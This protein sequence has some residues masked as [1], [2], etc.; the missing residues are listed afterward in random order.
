ML[1]LWT[2]F[3]RK[4][5]FTL[6][7][8]VA[9]LGVGIASLVAIP[10]ESSPE[11]KV[12]VGIVSVVLPGAS[13]EDVEQLIT[14]EIEDGVYNL[15]NLNKLTSRSSEG[16][17][18]VTVEFNASADLDK[19]IQEL[20]DE[21][22]TIKPRL[23]EEAEDP[24]VSEVNFA[25]QPVLI[26][27]VSGDFLPSEL[28][29]L[30]ET[31][32]DELES[33]G[34]VGRVEVSGVRNREVQV[35]V[36]REKLDQYN[37][38]LIDV[39]TAIQ[40][41][42]VSLPVGNI[43]VNNIEYTL[44]LKS[45][46][47]VASEVQNIP[48]N[49]GSGI[50]LYVRDVALVS[51]GV[52]AARSYSRLS[53]DGTPSQPALTINV[54][55]TAQANILSVAQD[56]TEKLEEMQ[57][58]GVI[59]GEIATV[60]DQADEI[61]RD[62]FELTETGAVTMLLVMLVLFVTL[63][64]RE[65]IVAGLSIPLSFLIAFIGLYVSGNS[66]NFVSLF[67]LILAI[68]ILVDSGIVVV[69][70]IHTRIHK[71]KTKEEAARASLE[72]YAWPLIAGTLTT[73]AVFVP[74]FF[75]SGIVGEF[76][77]SIP[78]TI[79]FVLMA[80]IFVALGLVPLITVM[81][82]RTERSRLEEIQD[83]YNARA[84]QWYRSFLDGILGNRTKENRFLIG[85]LVLFVAS[86]ALPATGAV[87]SIFF[88]QEDLNFIY[89]EIEK[90]AGTSLQ[91]TDLS[92]R[93]VEELLYDKPYIESFVS[94]TGSGSSF[95]QNAGSGARFAN[96][97][98]LLREDR[99]VTSTEAVEDLRDAIAQVSSADV[100]VYEPNNGPPTGAPVLIK[101]AGEDLTELATAV[102]K[103]EDLLAEIPGATEIT[104]S[105]RNNTT[106]F[107]FSVDRAKAA[108]NGLSPLLI[109]QTLRT[110][111]N[112][113]IATTI[114]AGGTD[115]DVL[116]KL[117]LNPNFRDPSE[118]NHVTADAIRQIAIETP[119]GPILLGSVLDVTLE[120]GNTSIT[121]EDRLRI[122]SVAA[123]TK[124]G[125]TPVAITQAFEE[126]IETVEIPEGVHMIVGGETEEVDRSFREMFFAFIG[127]LVLM[128]AILVL[129]FNSIRHTLYLLSV[130]PLS[131]IGVMFGLFLM[132]QP[133]S[134]SSLL[135]IIALAGVIINHAII[136]LDSMKRFE[137]QRIELSH[138]EVVIEAAA[139]RLRAILLTTITTVVGMIPLAGSSA[140]WGPLAYAIMFGLLFATVLTLLF[141]PILYYRWPGKLALA[142]QSPS[143]TLPPSNL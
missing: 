59:T 55:K 2:F 138:R 99:S 75:I 142:N 15:P 21:V 139:S 110:A 118:T 125:T 61:K 111:V 137:T 134:F 18:I 8:L 127:G 63:G 41:A 90:P 93:E 140:L 6:L 35:V 72:E 51:D 104:T 136:L 126:K 26:A 76:I 65:A 7:L 62:L 103:A 83:A 67:S 23:P 70:A 123:Y 124:P 130:V 20:K 113:A 68:G 57:R 42:N 32:I 9:L 74:L 3:L 58:T 29:E 17:S 30:S 14:N 112:G 34:G 121:H 33:V 27:S 71:Y 109:A 19:S 24:V 119:A 128:F 82:V 45:D 129:E 114:K 48:I 53:V 36:N 31:I 122:E 60:L 66:I 94:T 37:V 120:P 73:V 117:D 22:D 52:E 1:P 44:A 100:R 101:F 10:K 88:P 38:R 116:V 28:F 11:V 64:W 102:S 81:A 141:V 132:Q 97:T 80:S 107:A 115:I 25:D 47:D 131:L 98:I 84:Q 87:H 49:T 50:P 85:I 143:G 5:Q 91:A 105:T 92:T 86:I 56:A 96:I 78:F 43:I 135:G 4:R 39:A 46:V 133:L 13:A 79:I 77:A 12:P 106:Q 69:E 89:I 95:N 40:S 16:V 54:F 108:A